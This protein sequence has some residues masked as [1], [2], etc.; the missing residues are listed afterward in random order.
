LQRCHPHGCEG[1]SSIPAREFVHAE[2]LSYKK[3]AEQDRPDITRRWAQWASIGI[4]SISL[5]STL[6]AIAV[7]GGRVRV[8]NGA[9]CAIGV[10]AA[11]LAAIGVHQA[12]RVPPAKDIEIGIPGLAPEFDGCRLL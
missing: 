2:K 10:A 7:H 9:R 6:I 4:G 12:V 5:G 11:L 1:T 8:P 3:S